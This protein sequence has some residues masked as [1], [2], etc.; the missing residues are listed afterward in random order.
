MATLTATVVVLVGSSFQMK[1][2]AELNSAFCSVYG[3]MRASA[4]QPFVQTTVLPAPLPT[5]AGGK[6][7]FDDS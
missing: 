6:T 4:L 2:F 3:K 1:K 5:N 7:L